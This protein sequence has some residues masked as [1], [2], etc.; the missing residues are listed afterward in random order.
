MKSKMK[1]DARQKVMLRERLL[2]IMNRIN[3]DTESIR[4]NE[5]FDVIS[6]MK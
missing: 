6:L 4:I 3:Y 5:L 2:V 1:M